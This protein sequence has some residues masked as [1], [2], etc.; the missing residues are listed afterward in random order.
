MIGFRDFNKSRNYLLPVPEAEGPPAGVPLPAGVFEPEPL[1]EPF[2]PS[3]QPTA[4]ER[5]TIAMREKI[6]FISIFP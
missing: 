6:F 5:P 2:L 4:N 3:S 1:P